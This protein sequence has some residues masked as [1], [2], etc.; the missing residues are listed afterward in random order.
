MFKNVLNILQDIC[1]PAQQFEANSLN[2]L[3]IWTK[4]DPTSK[5]LVKGKS[6]ET[7]L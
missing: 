1:L 5:V 6:N 2:K 3:S 4:A 7:K